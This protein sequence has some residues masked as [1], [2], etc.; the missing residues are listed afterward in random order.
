MGMYILFVRIICRNVS[1]TILRLYSGRRCFVSGLCLLILLFM[2]SGNAMK[3][4]VLKILYAL[5]YKIAA[6]Y[7]LLIRFLYVK[8]ISYR[9]LKTDFVTMRTGGVSTRGIR[10]RFVLNREIVKACR[11]YGIY[12]N[13]WMLFFKYF[14]KVF[15]LF[16]R[17]KLNMA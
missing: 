1:V 13:M 15:E 4:T 12:T 5:D 2:R 10:S 8:R 16:Q 14:Y 3:N 11:K 17:K 9:Y 7:D 6:D